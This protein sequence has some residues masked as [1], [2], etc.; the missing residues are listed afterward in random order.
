V[1]QG[2]EYAVGD[3]GSVFGL[4]GDD[5]K[6]ER[7]RSNQVFVAGVDFSQ[8]DPTDSEVVAGREPKSGREIELSSDW[9]KDQGV[10]VGDRVRLATPTGIVDMRV[11]G[12]IEFASGLDLGGY[13]TG[14]MPIDAARPIMNKEGV[15]DE[16]DVKAE[17]GVSAQELQ[18]VLRRRLPEGVDVST[19][20]EKSDEASDQLASLDV[21]LYFFS[22]MALFVGAFLIT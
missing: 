4:V 3:I 19:P 1:V 12:L 20:S 10:G 6:V 5:G 16:I 15:F 14:S 8:P 9:A 22:G 2:V 13:G 21:V 18:T 11:V 17:E 7:G